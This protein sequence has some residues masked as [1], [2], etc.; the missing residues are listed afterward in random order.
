[1]L[2]AL[3]NGVEVVMLK[4]LHKGW[5]RAWIVSSMLITLLVF[6]MVYPAE[7]NQK[8][9]FSSG[10]TRDQIKT[11]DDETAAIQDFFSRSYIPEGALNCRNKAHLVPLNEDSDVSLMIVKCPR[12]ILDKFIDPL[13]I[14]I[15]LSMLLFFAGLVIAW[16]RKGF[17]QQRGIH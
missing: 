2:V 8:T 5:L 12:S 4:K 17:M 13:S 1:M 10:Y 9:W 3:V 16:V 7:G 6:A 11:Y 15:A 14:S